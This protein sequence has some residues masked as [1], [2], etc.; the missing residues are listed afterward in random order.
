M[1]YILDK[2]TLG[3]WADL[4]I[5]EDRVNYYYLLLRLH[6]C[7]YHNHTIPEVGSRDQSLENFEKNETKHILNVSKTIILLSIRDG[8]DQS[9]IVDRKTLIH[10]EASYLGAKA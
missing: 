7:S 2:P 5:W 6:V 10:K 9:L 8:D 3:I 4:G 1:A